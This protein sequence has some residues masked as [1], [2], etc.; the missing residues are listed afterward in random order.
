MKT[1]RH[2]SISLYDCEKY[3]PDSPAQ[4]FKK[5]G[6]TCLFFHPRPISDECLFYH[7]DG[8]EEVP[9]W[10]RPCGIPAYMKEAVEREIE[11]DK[12]DE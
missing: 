7:V 6:F 2:Y 8:P 5:A 4:A 3:V 10:M 1:D 11:E 12:T 9:E